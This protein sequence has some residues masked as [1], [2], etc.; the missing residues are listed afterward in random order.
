MEKHVVPIGI[1]CL[2]WLENV[3][4]HLY[5]LIIFRWH[6]WSE[7]GIDQWLPSTF[8]LQLIQRILWWMPDVD[9]LHAES[10]RKVITKKRM[11][12]TPA[13][14][15]N[16]LMSQI[17]NYT[18]LGIWNLGKYFIEM[19]SKSEADKTLHV[20]GIGTRRSI[21]EMIESDTLKLY[22]L[23]YYRALKRKDSGYPL[24]C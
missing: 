5:Y 1:H 2:S 6:Q 19:K 3:I 11:M 14:N 8:L 7:W 16:S 17:L 12:R 21:N 15:P 4:Y 10:F 24:G 22:T 18:E 13:E 20:I 23:Q 9:I